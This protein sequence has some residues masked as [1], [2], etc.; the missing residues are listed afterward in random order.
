MLPTSEESLISLGTF[1][2]ASRVARGMTQVR[3]ARDA[4]VSRKQLALLENGENISVKFLLRV[5]RYLELET[6]PLDGRVSLASGDAGLNVVEVL[7]YLDLI[8]ALVEQLRAFAM[9]AVLPPSE[10]GELKDTPALGEFLVKQLNSQT[11]AERLAAAILQVSDEASPRV[12][13]PRVAGEKKPP[14]RNAR[15]AE[16]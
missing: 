16:K 15:R 9:Q 1:V 8:G 4:K 12:R 5:A 11:G 7:R 2:R 6:L 3:V 13:R 14:A 10:R